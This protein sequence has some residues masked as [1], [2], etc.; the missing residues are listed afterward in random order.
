[1][2]SFSIS[3][4]SSFKFWPTVY[5]HGWCD[6]RPFQIDKTAEHIDTVLRLSDA[7][8]CAVRMREAKNGIRVTLQTPE[9]MASGQCAEMKQIILSMFRLT[10]SMDKFYERARKEPAFRWV[11]ASGGGRLLRSQSVFEDVVKMVSTTNCSWAL[12]KIMTDNLAVM[13][14]PEVAEGK[15]A[16]PEPSAIAAQSES[17]MRKEIRC[18][19]RAP[20]LLEF[21]E[22]VASGRRAVEQWRDWEGTTEELFKEM[23]SVKGVGEYAAGALMKLLGRYEYLG[24][25]SWCRAKFYELHSRGKTVSDAKIE[26]HYVSFGKWRG[27][28]LWMDVTHH[29]FSQ[30][31]PF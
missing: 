26:K 20:F 4:P 3:T 8:F 21:A 11:A 17:F 24:L 7:S 9:T 16:F 19:Y 27:L 25:D 6:L 13:L 23:R 10:E 1:M 14:G 5:S 29:W 31:F 30:K 18:G 22:S 12:T 15:H 28:F 2:K